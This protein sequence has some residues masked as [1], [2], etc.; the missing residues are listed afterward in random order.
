MEV[1]KKEMNKR[2]KARRAE[3]RKKNELKT[4]EEADVTV[5]EGREGGEK[6]RQGEG[7]NVLHTCEGVNC[8]FSVYQYAQQT[9]SSGFWC[10]L[11]YYNKMRHISWH[12]LI[13]ISMQPKKPKEENILINCLFFF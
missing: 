7:E 11:K 13:M 9:F 6:E 5:W 4:G 10:P 3:Q 2:G 1:I 8:Y 12:F